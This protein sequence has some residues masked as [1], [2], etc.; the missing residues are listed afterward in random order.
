MVDAVLGW[1]TGDRHR[2]RIATIDGRTRRCA[3]QEGNALLA[4]TLLGYAADLRATLLA[5]SLVTWQWPDGGWNCDPR[6]EASHSSFHETLAPLR[7]LAA[8]GKAVG[9]MAARAAAF[10]AA[11]LLL[12]HELVRRSRRVGASAAII[13]RGT[14][15]GRRSRRSEPERRDASDRDERPAA[16]GL[17]STVRH[18]L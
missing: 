9:D 18:P 17:T 14:A 5:R 8:Y 6:P 12:A 3:S 11:E 7:G 15:E 10:R 1:L 4:A 2:A 16:T 13:S